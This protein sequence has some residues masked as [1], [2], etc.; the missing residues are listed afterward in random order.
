MLNTVLRKK[1]VD[2]TCRA[3]EGHI[4]STFSI[5]DII[6]YL[7]DKVLRY[8]SKNPKWEDRDYFILSK[9]H[10]CAALYVVLEKQGSSVE[11]IYLHTIKPFDSELVVGSVQK[12]KKVFVIEEHCMYGG[13]GDEV[14]RSIRDI[15]G[16]KYSTIALKDEFIRK[17][18]SYEELCEMLGFSVEVII[19]KIKNELK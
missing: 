4:P 18:G 3:G 13:V 17:Y 8:D 14:L 1:I 6:A 9:G 16:V 15:S 2:M 11:I 19:N 10:G 12:T 5:V 7:Y